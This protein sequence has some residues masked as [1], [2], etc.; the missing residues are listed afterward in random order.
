MVSSSSGHYNLHSQCRGYKEKQSRPATCRSMFHLRLSD[1]IAGRCSRLRARLASPFSFYSL[2]CINL[3][4]LT[5]FCLIFVDFVVTGGPPITSHHRG[6]L[7]ST[8]SGG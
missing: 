5:T 7:T 1:L 2:L 8:D 4:F 6:P 3:W